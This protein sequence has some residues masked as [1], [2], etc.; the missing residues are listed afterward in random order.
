MPFTMHA[1][2]LKG[3][4]AQ[5]GA[6]IMFAVSGSEKGGIDGAISDLVGKP[7]KQSARLLGGCSESQ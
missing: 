1:V 5:A 2:S 6:G 3:E 4:T 7:S